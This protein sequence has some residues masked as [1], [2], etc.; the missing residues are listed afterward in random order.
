MPRKLKRY[1]G[2]G[3]LHFITFRVRRSPPLSGAPFEVPLKACLRQTSS[4][5]QGKQEFFAS[6]F[7]RGR[8]GG[9][10]RFGKRALHREPATVGGRYVNQIQRQ[11]AAW[12]PGTR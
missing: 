5:T 8:G 1:H 6:W 2:R 4:G 10:A 3:D 12:R 11:D 9:G 7:H